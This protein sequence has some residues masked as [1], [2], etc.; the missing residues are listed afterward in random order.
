MFPLQLTKNT[1]K[2]HYILNKTSMIKCYRMS[3]FAPTDIKSVQYDI[4]IVHNILF[5]FLMILAFCLYCIFTTILS[6]V[7]KSHNLRTDKTF[8]K[9]SMN[10]SGCLRCFSF[11]SD[12]PA[13]HFI[14]TCCKEVYQIESIVSGFYYFRDHSSFVF[15]FFIKVISLIACTIRNNFSRY[16]GINIFFYL[17]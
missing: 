16:M 7:L 10:N 13:S 11:P 14:M 3:S 4:S 17:S 8:F 1:I 5:T 12:G 6:K 9:V 2:P 15:V